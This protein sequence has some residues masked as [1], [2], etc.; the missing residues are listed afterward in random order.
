[1]LIPVPW[2][3]VAWRG[4]DRQVM[5]AEV[6]SAAACMH[7]PGSLPPPNGCGWAAPSCPSQGKGTGRL[8]S[9]LSPSCVAPVVSSHPSLSSSSLLTLPKLAI[10]FQRI[11]FEGGGSCLPSSGAVPG[12]VTYICL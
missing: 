4:P 7:S 1:M 2:T 11:E 8:T 5:L 3:K 10:S 6:G 12:Q 9:G